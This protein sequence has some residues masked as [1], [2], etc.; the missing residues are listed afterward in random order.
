MEDSRLVNGR[1]RGQP[2]GKVYT[3]LTAAAVNSADVAVAAK[4]SR[5]RAP[6]PLRP[7]R[8]Q[9]VFLASPVQQSGP[10]QRFEGRDVAGPPEQIALVG[11]AAVL[12]QEGQLLGRIHALG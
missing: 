12:A 6:S 11:L 4:Q 1:H 10:H 2:R 5:H 3:S 9:I 7:P 8:K